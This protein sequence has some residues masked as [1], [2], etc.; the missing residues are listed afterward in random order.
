MRMKTSNLTQV[1]LKKHLVYDSD[2]GLFTRKSTGRPVGY[3][4][5]LEGYS[6]IRIKLL[7]YKYLAHR[8]AF[9]YMRGHIPKCIDHIN[10][11][12]TD[13]RWVNL[14]EATVTQNQ[15][16]AKRRVDNTS[17][18][19]GVSWH[20]GK[21][22]WIARLSYKGKRINVGSFDSISEAEEALQNKRQ[23]L[24]GEYANNG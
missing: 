8:L 5:N 7:G 12:P 1:A 13:N 9:L 21:Q 24:H 18:V 20:K 2:T 17:S 11:D 4:N 6:A 15:Y 10:N 16:N 23:T 14:R 22:R 3:L 19:K